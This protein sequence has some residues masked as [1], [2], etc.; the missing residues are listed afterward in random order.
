VLRGAGVTEEKIAVVPNWATASWVEARPA[1]DAP[2]SLRSEWGLEGKLIVAYSGNFGRVHDLF[3]IL[4]VAERLKSD[5]AIAFVMI[6]GGAQ[7]EGLQDAARSRGLTNVHFQ[8]SQPRARLAETLAL[9]DVHL[10]TLRR[11]CERYVFPSKL[12]G[13][14]AVGRPVIFIG[15]RESQIAQQIEDNEFGYA[16]ASGETGL[17]ADA[18]RR[19]HLDPDARERLGR[20]AGVFAIGNGGVEVA[21]ASWHRLLTGRE[22]AG[23]WRPT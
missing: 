14:A 9:G 2:R 10:V 5:S 1:S 22:L 16:F 3:P 7:R 17:I 12:Y 15:P 19:L 20:A 18:I 11:G 21:A 13:I 6:G 8:P 23:G 4:A